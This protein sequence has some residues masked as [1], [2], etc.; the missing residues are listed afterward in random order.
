MTKTDAQLAELDRLVDR[1]ATDAATGRQIKAAARR[2]ARATI[3]DLM[4]S[5]RRVRAGT[6]TATPEGVKRVKEALGTPSGVKIISH[7]DNR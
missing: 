7:G 1:T 4:A 5:A 6:N 3:Q 2:V